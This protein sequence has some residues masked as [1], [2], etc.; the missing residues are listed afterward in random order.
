MKNRNFSL[1]F[2][3][4]LALAFAASFASSAFAAD[5]DLAELRSD[6][7]AAFHR[8]SANASDALKRAM[9]DCGKGA[10]SAKFKIAKV[11]DPTLDAAANEEIENTEDQ[12]AIKIWFTLASGVKINPIEHNWSPKEKFYVHLEATA[13][14]Y[15]SLFHDDPN[16]KQGFKQSRLV[17]PDSR[18]QN[19]V[20]PIQ[21]C[22]QTQLPVLFE[23]D[24][25]STEELMSMVVVRADWPGIQN[26][27]TSQATS[28]IANENG[29]YRV[30]SELVASAE[31][32]LTCLNARAA[33]TKPLALRDVKNCVESVGQEIDDKKAR[34]IAKHVNAIDS[35]KFRIV[36]PLTDESTDVD[37][38]CF[39]LFSSQQVGQWQ[40]KI[41]K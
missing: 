14:V 20:K 12:L 34:S 16:Q 27:L 41:T 13:P 8:L 31:G 30:T 9:K 36:Q 2:S 37:E 18:Y 7:Q 24:D 40:L 17:Y 6:A 11:E 26:D 39:Y 28:S 25:N 38:I 5:D 33:S 32:T 21:A 3:V 1:P 10:A 15:V 19:N 35:P 4:S 29:V 22:V 23:M